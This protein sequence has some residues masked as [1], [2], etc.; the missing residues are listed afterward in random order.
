M[1][2]SGSSK[3]LSNQTQVLDPHDGKSLTSFNGA[4]TWTECSGY[5]PVALEDPRTGISI[6]MDIE[7]VE[8]TS[9]IQSNI[10]CMEKM[11]KL[12]SSQPRILDFE[13]AEKSVF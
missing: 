6:K 11:V 8:A 2:D 4:S 3:H 5:I 9:G 10:L 7:N 13:V 1:L 12:G